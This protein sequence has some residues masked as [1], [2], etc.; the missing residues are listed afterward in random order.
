[1]KK[2]ITQFYSILSE[3]DK[4]LL[5]EYLCSKPTFFEKKRINIVMDILHCCNLNCMG[6]G[7][8]AQ[9]TQKTILN[10]PSPSISQI[11]TACMKIK[12]FSEKN[13]LDVFINIGGGEPFLRSDITEVIDVIHHF[14]GSKSIGIDT[15][16]SLPYSYEKIKSVLPKISYLGISLNGLKSYHNWWSNVSDFDAYDNTTNVIKKL[17]KSSDYSHKIEVTS[18]ATKKNSSDL[19]E[20]IGIL[21]SFGV[22]KY[23]VHRAIPVGRMKNQYSIMPDAKDYLL[24]LISLIKAAK[25]HQMDF[26]IHHSIENIHKTLLLQQTTFD[27]TLYSDA[28]HQSSIGITPEGD[29]VFNAWCMVDI[30]KELSCGNVFYSEKTLD[31]M[32]TD[33]KTKYYSIYSSSLLDKR[34]HGCKEPCSGGNRIVAASNALINF[35]MMSFNE[36]F[37]AVDPACPKY[38]IKEK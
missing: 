31:D 21:S 5:V 28:N 1:M 10:H 38:T 2:N 9:K 32:F 15:N 8:N 27:H 24:L 36:A 33:A 13:N 34:C 20:L 37:V 26:H 14:F 17:C 25:K 3:D 6:C 18:V 12:H 4:S 23:S 19:P 11:K 29:I 16:A 30:W 35:P 22:K 7:T